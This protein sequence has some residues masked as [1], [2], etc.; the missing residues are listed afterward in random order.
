MDEIR[1][2]PS[3]P[4]DDAFFRRVELHTT[5]ESLDP[6]DRQ[7][8]RPEDVR[9]SL[10]LTHEL[11]LSREGNQ[12]VVA[13]DERGERLGLLWFGVNR[14]LVTGEDEAWIF[15]VTVLPEHQGKGIGRRLMEHAEGL[16]RA[17][18]FR[19]LGLMVSS[20]NTRAQRLYENLDYRST[21]L[22]MRKKLA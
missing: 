10:A 4:A 20:H 3:T 12:V 7:R 11:L 21:N 2:R 1:F 22:V 5:W 9:E 13:E 6:E 19:R 14:N 18:G 15:N 16:A 8:L 17:G